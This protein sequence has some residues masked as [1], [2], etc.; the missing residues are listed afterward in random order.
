MKKEL[1]NTERNVE[2]IFNEFK[3]KKLSR[4][5]KKAKWQS[6]LKIML[7]SFL[8]LCVSFIAI[9]YFGGKVISRHEG[10]IYNAISKFNNISSPNKYIGKFVRYHGFL[11]YRIEY[12]TYKLLMGK[13]VFAG[14]EEYSYGLFYP[15]M[16]EIMIGAEYPSILG[17]S[18]DTEDLEYRKYN[19]FGLRE[20]VFFLPICKI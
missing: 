12:S 1:G 13:V 4:V 16:G 19:E 3:D 14:E 7:I 18:Y 10:I 15:G 11:A 6:A 9:S 8:V 17:F 5:V 2:K 20:M